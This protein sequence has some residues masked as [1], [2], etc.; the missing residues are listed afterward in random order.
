VSTL[1][2]A[3]AL[4]L[5]LLDGVLIRSRRHCSAALASGVP[6]MKVATAVTDFTTASG[7]RRWSRITVFLLAALSAKHKVLL[8]ASGKATLLPTEVK[9]TLV[10]FFL[11]LKNYPK[12]R[13]CFFCLFSHYETGQ[14]NFSKESI[15]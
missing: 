6:Q 5:R 10:R 4:L 13:K 1:K 11:L 8:C 2:E 15:A 7:R 3:S 12:A 9:R 14:T